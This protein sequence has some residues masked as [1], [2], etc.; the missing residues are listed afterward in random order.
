[1]WR[2]IRFIDNYKG[3][4]PASIKDTYRLLEKI[5]TDIIREIGEDIIEDVFIPAEQAESQDNTAKNYFIGILFFKYNDKYD[6]QV[7]CTL[8]RN[9]IRMRSIATEEQVEKMRSDFQ[10]VNQAQSMKTKFNVGDNVQVMSGD[11][12]DMF[13][14]IQHINGEDVEVNVQIFGRDHVIVVNTSMIAKLKS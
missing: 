8:D 6:N 13:G 5:R 2:C 4:R 14:T 12:K 1:M 10:S 7:L 9:S 11:Y 3:K